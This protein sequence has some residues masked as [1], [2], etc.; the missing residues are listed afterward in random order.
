VNDRPTLSPA[1]EDTAI[2]QGVLVSLLVEHPTQLTVLDL[3]RERNDPND[4]CDQDAVNRAVQ[5]LVAAGL[6]H[7][8]G[9]F[10]VPSRPALRFEELYA[11]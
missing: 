6:A 2:Q 10:V 3:Y 5:G 8:N 11:L 4:P 7:R 9:T 1:E